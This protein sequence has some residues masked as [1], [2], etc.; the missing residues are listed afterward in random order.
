MTDPQLTGKWLAGALFT[1]MSVGLEYVPFFAKWWD[2]V[3]SGYKRLIVAAFG[4]VLVAILI[5]LHYAGVLGLGLSS[6][7]WPVVLEGFKVWLAMIGGDWAVW[8]ALESIGA[9][10]RKRDRQTVIEP[11]GSIYTYPHERE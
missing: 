2:K 11:G 3:Q 5:G 9:I 10:P 7:G 8:G 6:F 4:A 1:L